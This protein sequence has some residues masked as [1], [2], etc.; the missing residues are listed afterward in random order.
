MA[1]VSK[2]EWTECTWNPVTGCDKVSAGCKYCYAEVMARRLKAMGNP[3][4]LNG[5]NITIHWEVLNQPKR[6]RKPRIIFVNSMS[7]L[8]H[9][10]VPRD[11]I[12]AAF[13]VMNDCPQHTFQVLTKRP[14][15]AAELAPDLP[16]SNNI[17]LGTSVEN[18]QTIHRIHQLR[19]IPAHIRFL[20]L[21]PLLG[22][23][24]RVPL[25][26]IHWVIVGGESGP[27]SRP[28]DPEWVRVIRDRC[29][30]YSVPFFF[31]QWGGK[32]K[33]KAGRELDGE[34]WD[35]IPGN[36]NGNSG[37]VVNGRQ[38]SHNLGNSGAY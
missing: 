31:K 33:K 15:R 22:R 25:Q 4:Y 20:S 10:D 11:F 26:G 35:Q 18:Q 5:F 12:Q 36:G 3:R 27:Q 23:I 29:L 7:D 9:E 21:E 16:W 2:I 6:W 38:T 13:A 1:Q 19:R 37:D 28:M 14:Q 32:N 17:W 24:N 34:F 30:R 8:F